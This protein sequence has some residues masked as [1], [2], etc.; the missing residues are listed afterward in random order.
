MLKNIIEVNYCEA[1]YIIQASEDFSLDLEAEEIEFT[2]IK[3]LKKTAENELLE[4]TNFGET[5]AGHLLDSYDFTKYVIAS[6]LSGV[7]FM[8][9]NNVDEM[10]V[11]EKEKFFISMGKAGL[12]NDGR[13]IPQIILNS[14][15][16]K[17]TL[18]MLYQVDGKEFIA[19]AGVDDCDICALIDSE[20]GS[21]ITDYECFYTSGILQDVE[22]PDFKLV[23]ITDSI[24]EFL[25]DYDIDADSLN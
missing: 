18:E 25:K 20:D 16:S 19:Y 4:V 24:R 5:F 21:L 8:T 22:K 1:D 17:L 3:V 2:T 7:T 9:F 13:S 14:N 15:L 12:K 6:Y 11:S 23:I 10:L